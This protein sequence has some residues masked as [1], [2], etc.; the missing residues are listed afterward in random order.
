[1]DIQNWQ[2]VFTQAIHKKFPKEFTAEQRLLAIHRQL[3]DVSQAIQF[4]EFGGVSLNRRIAAIL[5][6]FFMLCEQCGV[7]LNKELFAVE[8]W[9]ESGQPKTARK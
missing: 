1:M 8:Q 4:E 6:D 7:D 5:P 9:F 2:N 3:S